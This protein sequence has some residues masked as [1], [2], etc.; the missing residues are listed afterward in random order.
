LKGNF[1]IEEMIA[2]AAD[3]VVYRAL[4]QGSGRSVELTRFLPFGHSGG[5]LPKPSRLCFEKRIESLVEV[6]HPALRSVIGG[7]C[8]PNDGIPFVALDWLEAQ[9]LASVLDGSRLS[10][11][12]TRNLMIGALQ[13][14]E[15]ISHV[16]EVDAVWVETD[17]AAI[18]VAD[19][20]DGQEIIFSISVVK[21]VGVDGEQSRMEPLLALAEQLRGWQGKL[22]SDDA[23]EG[24]GAWIKWLR[25]NPQVSVRVARERLLADTRQ[26]VPG[27]GAKPRGQGILNPPV[28]LVERENP[29]WPVG[30]SIALL[31]LVGCLGMVMASRHRPADPIAA[32]PSVPAAAVA[33]SGSQSG[34][35]PLVE[36]VVEN[37][38]DNK[39]AA[40]AEAET[41]AIDP[42]EEKVH[43]LVDPE[44]KLPAGVF[45]T[46]QREQILRCFREQIEIEGELRQVRL[47]GNRKIWYLEFSQED[48]SSHVRAYLYVAD[49]KREI[50]RADLEPLLGRRVRLRGRVDTERIKQVRQPKLIMHSWADVTVVD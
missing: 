17:P 38:E 6:V 23:G 3:R 29:I 24:L 20:G 4:N 42:R 14:S 15:C 1:H 49:A 50:T 44:V 33:S 5:G 21:C 26:H 46:R 31:L 11:G 10:A 8:D 34:G 47:S 36:A 25:G 41:P 9:S 27:Q 2:Q 32:A 37:A 18:R 12:D 22:V 7:G 48:P 28:V 35:M 30:I 16:F 43:P 39:G 45:D 19:R 40:L 13:V